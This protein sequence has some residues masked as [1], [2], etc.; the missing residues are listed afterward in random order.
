MDLPQGYLYRMGDQQ[1][2]L[3]ILNSG[4]FGRDM[5]P[6]IVRVLNAGLT[7]CFFVG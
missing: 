1:G 5:D 3:N 7:T 6:D 2:F 4:D